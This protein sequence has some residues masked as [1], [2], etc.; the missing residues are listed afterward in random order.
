MFHSQ[1]T[2]DAFI[3]E[4][5][6]EFVVVGFSPLRYD[7]AL[8]V[9]TET[10]VG[11]SVSADSDVSDDFHDVLLFGENKE[12]RRAV[13]SIDALTWAVTVI[14]IDATGDVLLPVKTRKER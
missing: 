13:E 3:R 7:F 11:L 10:F 2:T 9:E 4:H 6:D 14:D 12:P 1:C 5:V 8:D